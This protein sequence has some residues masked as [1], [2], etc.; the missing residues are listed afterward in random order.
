MQELKVAWSANF[1]TLTYATEHIP[2]SK[3]GKPE[4]SKRDV[5]LFFKRLRKSHPKRVGK[6]S[7]SIKY[8]CAGEYGSRTQ[9]PHYHIILFNADITKIQNAWSMGQCHYGK[10]SAASIGY[11]LKYIQKQKFKEQPGSRTPEFSLMSKGLGLSYLSEA[12]VG[13]HRKDLDNRTYVNIEDKKVSMPRY[14][15]LKIYSEM[16]RKR[17]AFLNSIRIENEETERFFSKDYSQKERNLAYAIMSDFQRMY[18]RA[19]VGRNKI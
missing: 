5:Q 19:Q 10:V 2:I 16:E 3:N 8:Y 6:W 7:N 9:R 11:T 17:I 12:M 1:I 15:K 13:W 14:Y 18:K 4:L